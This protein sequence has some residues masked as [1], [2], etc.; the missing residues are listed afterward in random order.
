[1]TETL[2]THIKDGSKE[3]LSQVVLQE[4]P[5]LRVFLEQKEEIRE[6]NRVEAQT[7]YHLLNLT[8]IGRLREWRDL[9]MLFDGEADLWGEE[10]LAL[11]S[12]IEIFNGKHSFSNLKAPAAISMVVKWL[13][14]NYRYNYEYDEITTDDWVKQRIKSIH[15]DA[16]WL[17]NSSIIT[18][19]YSQEDPSMLES[20]HLDRPIPKASQ[21]IHVTR[22]KEWNIDT[23][24]VWRFL[25]VDNKLQVVYDDLWRIWEVT[26]RKLWVGEAMWIWVDTTRFGYIWNEMEPSAIMYAPAFTLK[27][28]RRAMKKSED[29]GIIFFWISGSIEGLKK[30]KWVDVFEM[31]NNNLGFPESIST[32]LWAS[33]WYWRWE[34][35]SYDTNDKWEITSSSS[36]Q[37][38]VLFDKQ[39]TVSIE[40]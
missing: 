40:Y 10:T 18:F 36:S 26:Q 1:M 9:D 5:E 19:N 25:A 27:K 12:I 4:N 23:L 32:N 3:K 16:T 11:H 29:A 22:D 21:E 31:K 39:M 2:N 20:L 30:I 37:E 34:E 7:I 24:G 15:A 8:T 17:L 33:R 13:R 35:R 28:T 38:R 6:N 14:K